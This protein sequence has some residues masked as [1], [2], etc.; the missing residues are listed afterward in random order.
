V[1]RELDEFK[2]GKGIKKGPKSNEK[3]L[4]ANAYKRIMHFVRASSHKSASNSAGG[5]A[6]A[7]R[8]SGAGAGGGA[9]AS[10]R[11]AK[12]H[13]QRCAVRVSF[14]GNVA[15]GGTPGQWGAHGRYIERDSAQD[16]SAPGIESGQSNTVDQELNN[17]GRDADTRTTIDSGITALQESDLG[18]AQPRRPAR[19]LSGL[20]KLSALPVVRFAHRI[21]ELLPRHA[22]DHVGRGREE[23]ADPLR[24]RSDGP[25]ATTSGSPK[26]SKEGVGRVGGRRVTHAAFGSA[27]QGID[28]ASTLNTWQAAG[29][30][31]MF[32]LIVSAEFGDRLDHERHTR[33]LLAKMEADLNTRLEWVAVTHWNTD[34]PHTHVALRGIDE[35]GKALRLPP[36]Y[37]KHVIR[38]HAASLATQELGYRTEH[39]AM[40][41][42]MREVDAQRFTGLDSVIQK[43]A[44]P[45]PASDFLP[46]AA[47]AGA[48]NVRPQVQQRLSVLATMGLAQRDENGTWQVRN[49]FPQVLRTMQKIADRQ[50]SL[51]AHRALLSD[52]RLPLQYTDFKQLRSIEGRVLGHGQDEATAKTYL[53]LEGVEGKVH[54]LYHDSAIMAARQQKQMSPGSFVRIRKTFEQSGQRMQPRITVTDYGDAEKVLTN[55]QYLDDAVRRRARASTAHPSTV[56][57]GWLGRH[58]AAIAAHARQHT[59]KTKTPTTT[60]R[61]RG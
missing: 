55:K 51:H 16:L 8:A 29:D 20:R 11:P 30:E 33:G 27:G 28:A 50:R 60:G 43:A 14:A 7:A 22:H 25:D 19:T 23:R 56:Y 44:T 45:N 32:K 31:R 10:P 46:V 26:T 17:E 9:I 49:D 42:A 6:K 15:Q 52:E 37:I 41:A 2:L 47:N 53:L 34:H 35:E 21:A 40:I 5:S 18:E 12:A 59:P 1:A 24:R 57:G 54:Y 36:N 38:E 13:F 61:N 58:E 4:Y 48:R 39:D 3:K